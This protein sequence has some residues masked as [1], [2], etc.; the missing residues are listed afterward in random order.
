MQR[1]SRETMDLKEYLQGQ[2]RE[3]MSQLQ[4][5]RGGPV[6]GRCWAQGNVPSLSGE[7][8][9]LVLAPHSYLYT[10]STSGLADAQLA[11]SVGKAGV[12]L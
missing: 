3:N 4:S 2:L 7:F 1:P 9:S 10:A 8:T 5:K 11:P 12:Q 6:L